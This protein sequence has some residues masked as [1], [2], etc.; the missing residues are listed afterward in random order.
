MLLGMASHNRSDAV[1][2]TSESHNVSRILFAFSHL[3]CEPGAK[4]NAAV[5]V[6]N[7]WLVLLYKTTLL[8]L[9][10]T[11]DESTVASAAPIRLKVSR[12]L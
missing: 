3:E 10:I 5:A 11:K 2:F 12:R 8:R 1:A 4:G 9:N 6:F 7:Q